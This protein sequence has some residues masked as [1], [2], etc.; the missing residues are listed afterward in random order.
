M[1]GAA[2]KAS[3]LSLS[4]LPAEDVRSLVSRA[5]LRLGAGHADPAPPDSIH[6]VDAALAGD[7]FRF[8]HVLPATATVRDGRVRSPFPPFGGCPS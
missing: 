5:V 2:V 8:A 1:Q 7:G 6:D 3:V 4:W